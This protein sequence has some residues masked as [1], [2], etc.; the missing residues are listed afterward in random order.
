MA[1][2]KVIRELVVEIKQKGS[3]KAAKDVQQLAK[4]LED[5]SAGAELANNEFSQMAKQLVLIERAGNKAGQTLSNIKIPGMDKITGVMEKMVRAIERV[6]LAIDNAS[7]ASKVGMQTIANQVNKAENNIVASADRST[8]AIKDMGREIKIAGDK[9]KLSD[10]D[11]RRFIRSVGDTS[12]AARG[13]TRDFAALSMVTGKLPMLYGMIASNVFALGQ[14]FRMAKLGEQTARL[15]KIGIALGAQTGTP[16]QVLANSLVEATNG[17]LSFENAMEKA[18]K[19]SQYGFDSDQ[20]KTI[21]MIASRQAAAGFTSTDDAINRIMEGTAKLNSASLDGAGL[22]FRLVDA[23]SAYATKLNEINPAIQ[24][25]SQNL[26]TNQK[27][28]AILDAMVKQSTDN[29]GKLDDAI[30][31]ASNYERLTASLEGAGKRFLTVVADHFLPAV[32]MIETA[33]NAQP[34][35]LAN[36]LKALEESSKKASSSDVT[37]NLTLAYNTSDEILKL[38]KEIRSEEERLN[39]ALAK[40]NKLDSANP[41]M[42]DF[43]LT[44][45][46]QEIKSY[47]GIN[48]GLDSQTRALID[49]A[50]ETE[51]AFRKSTNA[52]EA[53]D[54]AMQS[55]KNTAAQLHR[56]LSEAFG[57]EFADMIVMME[58][59]IPGQQGLDKMFNAELL[60]AISPA[61]KD[62]TQSSKDMKTNI[63][64]AFADVS[65]PAKIQAGITSINTALNAVSLGT[66]LVGDKFGI[67]AEKAG[68]TVGV[69]DTIKAQLL[70]LQTLQGLMDSD[71]A[72]ALSDAKELYN[73][74]LQTRNSAGVSAKRSE[75]AQRDLQTK[76][77][78]LRAEQEIAAT[79]ADRKSLASQANAIEAQ[80]YD[81]KTQQILSQQKMNKESKFIADYEMKMLLLKDRSFTED[82]LAIKLKMDELD[83]AKQKVKFY[84]GNI[85]KQKE[86]N[87]AVLEEV[88]IQRDLDK[89]GQS[90]INK[91]MVNETSRKFAILEAQA[92]SDVESGVISVLKAKQELDDYMNSLN[93]WEADTEQVLKYSNAIEVAQMQLDR[94]NEERE[95]GFRNAPSSLLGGTYNT[96]YGMS[97]DQKSMQEMQNKQDAYA[98]ALSS[99]R[100]INQEATDLATNLGNTINSVMLFAEGSLDTVGMISAGM[101]LVSSGIAMATKQQVSAIDNAIKAEHARD[102]KSEESKNKIKKLEAE[103]VK[104]QQ[105]AAKKQ[106][107]IQTAMAVMNAANAVPYPWSIPLMVAAA[108]AGMMAYSQASNPVSPSIDAGGSQTGY[109][110]LGKRDNNVDVSKGANAGEAKYMAGDRG[111]GSIQNFI[112]RAAGGLMLPGVGYQLNEKGVEFKS[113]V[114]PTRVD[115]NDNSSNNS[116]QSSSGG[117]TFIIQAMDSESFSSFLTRHGESV[118]LTVESQLN[119]EGKTLY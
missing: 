118:A 76:L 49:Q 97:D 14:A 26:T 109:L 46:Y 63:S 47:T 114:V 108:A 52:L 59:D 79:E 58:S 64:E 60:E 85:K 67:V 19:A 16:V 5:A 107:L 32:E 93:G 68:L 31:S 30:K 29:Y 86:L 94:L 10:K 53:Y 20:L 92:L 25:N 75:I 78:T 22:T 13:A 28:M 55:A 72:N 51:I 110:R 69:L 73:Y 1:S 87:D 117:N 115:R 35:A 41:L 65:N 101:Q 54:E 38:T 57:K 18:V 74:A 88:Q 66:Q 45:F 56:S 40:R 83:I 27:K 70:S 100:S 61:L 50:H 12:G 106:I 9:A 90:Y 89:L 116:S 103:K 98:S 82:Q 71:N 7:D 8:D 6:E 113:P 62:I 11:F 24:A 80:I 17:A 33:L 91:I 119:N 102:G 42:R 48:V 84:T 4:A 105:D 95:R 104:I 99:L 77:N 111:T 2:D 112:P 23:Y 43:Q 39:E 37:A 81:L 96:T 3:A 21:G 36:S 34:V 44:K 15:Q